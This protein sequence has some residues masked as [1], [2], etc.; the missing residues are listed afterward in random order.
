MDHMAQTSSFL[1]RRRRAKAAAMPRSIDPMLATAGALPPDLG[2]YQFE[3]KWDGVRALCFHDGRSLRLHSRNQID[4]NS[5]Y[6][7]LQRM[8]PAL[9]KRSAILDGEIVALD[10]LGRSSFKRLQRRMHVADP[11]AALQMEVPILYVIFD[12]LYLDGRSLM[13]RP[14]QERRERLEELTIAGPHWQITSAH[15]GEGPAMLA[16]ARQNHLEGIIAK[17]LDGAYEP[18]RRSPS[19]LKIKIIQRQEFVVGGWIPE[20]GHRT[21]R[22]GSMLLGYHDGGRLR[23]AG[24]IGTG[25]NDAD[26]AK[27]VR[28]FSARLRKTS[29]FSE[30][31]PSAHVQFIAP[32]VVV[33]V[34]Y[35]RWPEGGLVQQGAFKGV[36]SDKDPRQ[37]VKEPI[38][39]A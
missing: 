19:W 29:P 15:V 11:P 9:E 24:R 2:S 1:A 18:G 17:R 5:R 4:I 31:V 36:R 13:E 16:A 6:P 23:Y 7:E 37:V 25:L 20:D 28:M 22:I 3:W 39:G 34:E 32:T 38:T 30:A 35:R 21:G 14:C 26:H 33:E 12:L 10:D 27:L 8:L